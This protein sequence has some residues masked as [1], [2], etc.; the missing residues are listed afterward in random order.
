[1]WTKL[2]A[3]I[4]ATA[5]VILTLAVLIVTAVFG[6]LMMFVSYFLL[7]GLIGLGVL[8]FLAFLIYCAVTEN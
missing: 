8:S 2:K 1:M 6:V 4:S 3:I 7:W 5:G